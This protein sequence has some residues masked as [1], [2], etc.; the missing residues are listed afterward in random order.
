MYH[1]CPYYEYSMHMHMMRSHVNGK[2]SKSNKSHTINA[3]E[4]YVYK[5][6]E[7]LYIHIFN[8]TYLLHIQS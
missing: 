3:Y 7:H 6:I 5:Y 2:T 4:Q 8:N 1:A